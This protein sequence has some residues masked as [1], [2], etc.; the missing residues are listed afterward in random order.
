LSLQLSVTH[1]HC[2]FFTVP[3][4]PVVEHFQ[5]PTPRAQSGRYGEFILV[6]EPDQG[7]HNNPFHSVN[8]SILPSAGK[9]RSV[10]FFFFFDD[11]R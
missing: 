3:E 10:N 4:Q 1:D 7:S 9:S 11:P 6:A 2:P 5:F 8:E